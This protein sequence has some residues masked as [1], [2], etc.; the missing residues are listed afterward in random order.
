MSSAI[1]NIPVSVED[2]LQ[3]ELTRDVKHELIDGQIYAKAGTSANHERISGNILAEFNHH[4]KA[5][6]CEPFGSD[7][8]VKAGAKFF[9]PDVIVDCQF[10]ESHY[11]GI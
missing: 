1:R 10:D 3:D 5:S 4:L 8:K 6:P 9:Y 11:R 7:M 2:Y